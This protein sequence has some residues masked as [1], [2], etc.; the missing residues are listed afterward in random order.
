M[1]N[2][3]FQVTIFLLLKWIRGRTAT[4]VTDSVMQTDVAV[5]HID[6]SGDRTC[7]LPVLLVTGWN[8]ELFGY[9][10]KPDMNIVIHIFYFHFWSTFLSSVGFLCTFRKEVDPWKKFSFSQGRSLTFW[11]T[12]HLRPLWDS[13]STGLLINIQGENK[14]NFNHSGFQQLGLF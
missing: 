5:T 14:N 3:E 12:P 11:T 13:T 4:A 6:R 2:G 1:L 7:D 8:L 10:M 9:L